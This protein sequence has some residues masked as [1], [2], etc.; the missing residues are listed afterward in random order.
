MKQFSTE[1]RKV[2]NNEYL[3]VFIMYPLIETTKI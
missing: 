3:K 2:L 1:K